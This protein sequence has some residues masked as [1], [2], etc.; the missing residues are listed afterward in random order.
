MTSA[1]SNLLRRYAVVASVAVVSVLAIVAALYLTGAQGTSSS[2]ATTRTVTRTVWPT[3][4]PAP[5]TATSKAAWPKTIKKT[6]VDTVHPDVPV[7][8]THPPS[9]SGTP[10]NTVRDSYK[11]CWDF[12]WQQ[13]AQAAYL[14]N[15]S[16]PGGLDGLAG[17]NN[18]DG[19]ACQQL[20]VDPSRTASSPIGAAPAGATTT[21]T[22]AQVEAVDGTYFGASSD[23][24]PGDARALDE[25]D[26]D[27]G[28]APGL[29]EFFDTWDHPYAATKTKVVQS[30]DQGAFPVLTWMPEPKGGTNNLDLPNYSLDNILAGNWDVY[31]YQWAV[32]VVNTGMP[33]GM[34]FAHE[35]NGSW[36]PWSAGLS[37]IVLKGTTRVPLNN[38]PAK[39]NAVWQH[40]WQI[41]QDV[42]ANKYTVWIWTPVTSLCTQHTSKKGSGYCGDA[43]TTYAEDYPGN[44][45]VDWVGLSSY[46]YG[47]NSKYSFSGTFKNSLS[48]MKTV[49][50]KP[51][52]VAETGASERVTTP[53]P[54]DKNNSKRTFAT[55]SSRTDLKVQWTTQTLAGFL[56]QGGGG[57]DDFL[58]PGQRVIGFVL[59][60]NYVPNVHTINGVRSETDWRWNSSPEAA[61]AFRAGVADPRYRGGLMPT[62]RLTAF[63]DPNSIRWPVIDPTSTGPT[64]S[65]GG[66]S[67]GSGAPGSSAPGSSA[68]GSSAPGSSSASGSATPTSAPGS[69]STSASAS[70]G[71]GDGT[72]NIPAVP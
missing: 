8:P 20:P 54:D 37:S 22:K 29:L 45:Y 44:D 23:A 64:S 1:R 35:M 50:D 5:S 7:S 21:P 48:M 49:S 38:T 53:W 34:R 40:I 16:D 60:N 32:Q 24:L 41:F 43:Y 39:F 61:A 31:L 13:D 62:P 10:A 51:L 56:D 66:S 59:F 58:N 52:Y 69:P 26:S 4:S 28:K 67:S 55:E 42:G 72:D 70:A 63:T 2:A 57:S 9:E 47:A 65:S 30:W 68:P 36:Y 18:G 27:V 17:P 3:P 33:M 19:V 25:L 15:L 14:A 12:R 6:V 46:A 71:A 11:H